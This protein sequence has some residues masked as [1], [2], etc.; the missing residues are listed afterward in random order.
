[1]A[2][3]TKQDKYLLSA[4]RQEDTRSVATALVRGANVD[5]QDSEGNTAL[6]WAVKYGN[7]NLMRLLLGCGAQLFA[8]NQHHSPLSLAIKLN[9]TVFKHLLAERSLVKQVVLYRQPNY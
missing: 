6:H 3:L 5:S 2:M 9:Q 4:A 8:N 1:M 7:Q